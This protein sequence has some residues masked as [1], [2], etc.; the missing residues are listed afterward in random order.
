[1]WYRRLVEVS[2]KGALAEAAKLARGGDN[3]KARAAYQSLIGNVSL[4]RDAG[5]GDWEGLLREAY[6]GLIETQRTLGD[7]KTDSNSSRLSE[8]DCLCL[9]ACREARRGQWENSIRALRECL[10]HDEER[11]RRLEWDSA[12]CMP[13]AGAFLRAG[14]RDEA[15]LMLEQMQRL[16]ASDAAVAH[17][18][19]LIGL[20]DALWS[21]PE[22]AANVWAMV[23]RNSA[24]LLRSRGY[25]EEWRQRSA[26]VYAT[27]IKS[28]AILATQERLERRLLELLPITSSAGLDLRAE[29]QAAEAMEQLG[30]LPDPDVM[31]TF[32]VCGPKMLRRLGYEEHF[33]DFVRL[34]NDRNEQTVDAGKGQASLLSYLGQEQNRT[35]PAWDEPDGLL[36]LRRCFS[37][38]KYAQAFLEHGLP[39]NAID[40]LERIACP[41]CSARAYS[42]GAA[43]GVCRAD[44]GDF[45]RRNPAYASL[46]SCEKRIREDATLLA[47]EAHLALAD[48]QIL[49][50]IPDW[51]RLA[52]CL[53]SALRLASMAG[54]AEKLQQILVDRAL[55][56]AATL[57]KQQRVDQ[58][59]P[60]LDCFLSVLDTT[61]S[62]EISGELARLLNSRGMESASRPE[63]DWPAAI[64]DFRRSIHLNPTLPIRLSNLAIALGLRARQLI[65]RNLQVPPYGAEVTSSAH[66]AAHLLL[67]SK[68]V[69]DRIKTDFADHD[70]LA[71]MLAGTAEQ[72]ASLAAWLTTSGVSRANRSHYASGLEDLW[73]AYAL[74]PEETKTVENLQQVT[75]IYAADLDSRGARGRAAEVLQRALREFPN[76][77]TLMEVERTTGLSK[78]SRIE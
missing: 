43:P 29:M 61:I 55:A 52:R 78:K 42:M 10:A 19:L 75:A 5:S 77:K 59:I 8:S 73:M 47:A 60:L 15:V 33:A 24:L 16:D 25:W 6:S 34:M 45:A 65:E 49:A 51:P 11:R 76:S 56:R 36:K 4:A 22:D 35:V 12:I 26:R 71:E 54:W 41:Q 28:S 58:A 48:A 72:M 63:P 7:S 13:L 18:L 23:I 20:R 62:G 31:G 44:C 67:E 2:I 21:A 53:E 9:S 50:S 39:V 37:S 30:G 17:A 70:D 66:E 1:M 27:G 64:A 69:L 40:A 3:E 68:G 38:L 14:C 32:V 74:A 57:N 46:K